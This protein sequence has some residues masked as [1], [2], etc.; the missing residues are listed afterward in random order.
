MSGT[1]I[2][3]PEL[4]NMVNIYDKEKHLYELLPKI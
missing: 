3:F 2:P 4:E 1:L